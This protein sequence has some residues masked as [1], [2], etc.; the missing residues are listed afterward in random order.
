MFKTEKNGFKPEARSQPEAH[1]PLLVFLG[2]FS[3]SFV[4]QILKKEGFK[5][6]ARSQLKM[7]PTLPSFLPP[8][9][10]PLAS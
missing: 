10:A 6:E 9:F 3:V 5:P 7:R 2:G 4:V 8:V 1:P